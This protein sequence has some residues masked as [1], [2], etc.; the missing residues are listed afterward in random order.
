MSLQDQDIIDLYQD[1]FQSCAAIA[2]MDGCSE[3]TMYHRLKNLGVKIRDRSEANKIFPDSIFIK[4][5]NLGLSNS[6][7]ARLLGV[8]TSTVTKRL[9][10]IHFPLRI[11]D[12]AVAIRY[13]EEEFRKF[14]MDSSFV[15]KLISL[16]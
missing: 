8:N 12:V 7:V 11:R 14:F 16:C 1:K 5:Y 9:R 3:T 2:I 13:T 4:L 15:A 10:H 6:Q